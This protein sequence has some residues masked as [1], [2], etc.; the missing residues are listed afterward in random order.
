MAITAFSSTPQFIKEQSLTIPTVNTETGAFSSFTVTGLTPDMTVL[1]NPT[2]DLPN[3]I[4]LGAYYVSA[5]N[6]LKVQFINHTGGN[7]TGGAVTFKIM[8][9]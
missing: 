2:S 5:A 6:T 9:L 4:G 3:G 1:L 8:A 7:L